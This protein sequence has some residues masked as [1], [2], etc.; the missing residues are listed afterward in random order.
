M[1][2]LK[3]TARRTV[4]MFGVLIAVVLIT[5]IVV[6]LNLDLV[7]EGRIRTEVIAEINENPELC[8]NFSSID[9]CVDYWVKLRL[10]SL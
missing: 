3:F 8:D 9:E 5:S 2:F 6:S 7:L 10:E 1:G 4:T